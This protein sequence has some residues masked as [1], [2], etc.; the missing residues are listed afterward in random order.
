MYEG[1]TG[2]L[3]PSDKSY[4]QRA[5]ADIKEKTGFSEHDLHFIRTGKPLKINNNGVKGLG[6]YKTLCYY[7]FFFFLLFDMQIININ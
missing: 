4:L 1:I 6:A 2:S 5:L 7:Y 3:E